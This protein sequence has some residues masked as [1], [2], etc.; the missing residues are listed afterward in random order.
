[1]SSDVHS[2]EVRS[3]N[4]AAIKARD[5]KPE[6]I[7]RSALHSSGLRYRL[8]VRKLPGTP[9][10][11]LRKHGAVIF[12]HGCF[13][14]GHQ[15]PAFKWPKNNAVFWRGK[16]QGNRKRDRTATAELL[17]KEWRVLTVW[18]CALCGP[19]RREL[20]AVVQSVRRWLQSGASER[21]I[22]GVPPRKGRPKWP[23]RRRHPR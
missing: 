23:R 18:E 9:D 3:R 12:V 7:L 16:I 8:H 17:N 20:P 2:A 19:G 4:M 13:F 15:C 11:V 5:T 22:T 10:L 14:H 1:M 21:T 6:L